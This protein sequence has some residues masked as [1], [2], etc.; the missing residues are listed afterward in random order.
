[1]LKALSR[2]DFEIG[3][4]K[5]VGPVTITI[6]QDTDGTN[7]WEDC[8]CMTPIAWCSN[9]GRIND[10]FGDDILS[11]FSKVTQEWVAEKWDQLC[12]ILDLKPEYELEKLKEY[13]DGEVEDGELHDFISEALNDKAGERTS[14]PV[15]Y[16]DA[17]EAIWELMGIPA[18]AFQ[19]NGYSQGDCI[20]GIL[21]CTP[22][23]AKECGFTLNAPNHDIREGLKTDAALFGAW[24]FGDIYGYV[25]E[26]DGDQLDS[27]WG[28][29]G[30]PWGNNPNKKGEW[31]VFDA[32]M[33]ALEGNVRFRVQVL[34]RQIRE[35]RQGLLEMRA[36][37]LETKPTGDLVKSAILAQK[38]KH[39]AAYKEAKG[40]LVEWEQLGREL[41]HAEE[42]VS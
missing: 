11:P 36:E 31:A 16:F 2:H 1:M 5:K 13:N 35:S 41:C 30:S 20:C 15:D 40:K 22:E 12:K 29:Y 24:A 7:P 10:K 8:D 21:V 38:L 26:E 9:R 27:C 32:V 33:E 28:F 34:Q 18:H 19:V 25:I 42:S 14:W 6:E 37:V 23:H 3:K 17:L 39:I 4:P